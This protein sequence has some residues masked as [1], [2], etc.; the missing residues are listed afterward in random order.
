MDC[1]EHHPNRFWLGA[2]TE[3]KMDEIGGY[4][5]VAVPNGPNAVHWY[6]IPR[7][8]RTLRRVR[9]CAE[10]GLLCNVVCTC[11]EMEMGVCTAVTAEPEGFEVLEGATTTI[12]NHLHQLVEKVR[13]ENSHGSHKYTKNS[14]VEKWSQNQLV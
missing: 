2:K 10:Q 3:E 9:W 14:L 5:D 6:Q 7:R 4:L 13:W 11:K 1:P 12:S 8:D